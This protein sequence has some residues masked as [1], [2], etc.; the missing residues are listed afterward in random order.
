MQNRRKRIFAVWLAMAILLSVFAPQGKTAMADEGLST[1]GGSLSETVASTEM[2]TTD[3]EEVL[4]EAAPAPA[5][6]QEGST[7]HVQTGDPEEETELREASSVFRS[8]QPEVNEAHPEP[9]QMRTEIYLDGRNGNDI[10]DGSST[11]L[12]VKTFARAREIAAANPSVDTIFVIGTTSVSG[13]VTLA[14]THS[15]FSRR[16]RCFSPL[17]PPAGY[18]PRPVRAL[19]LCS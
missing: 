15:L 12:A 7:S 2:P 10:N 16:D 8:S 3:P 14:G 13:E 17:S 11:T 6:E 19:T 5:L 1:E 4:P 18:T 9:A